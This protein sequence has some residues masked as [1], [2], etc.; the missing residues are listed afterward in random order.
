MM[1]KCHY[2]VTGNA[3]AIGL[4]S[5]SRCRA[6]QG[7]ALTSRQ[8]PSTHARP[9]P[10]VPVPRTGIGCPVAVTS[11][12][13]RTGHSTVSALSGAYVSKSSDLTR[14]ST[15]TPSMQVVPAVGQFKLTQEF[16]RAIR[17]NCVLP[18]RRTKS[19]ARVTRL[20]ARLSLPVTSI[21]TGTWLSDRRT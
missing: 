2:D 19:A 6:G 7:P 17:R 9:G 5:E 20:L 14:A 1:S 21:R 12:I 15:Q 10:H 13:D 16:S 18:G 4:F 3:L 8:L 11:K